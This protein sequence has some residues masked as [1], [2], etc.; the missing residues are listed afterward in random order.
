MKIAV[1]YEE[2]NI[3]THFG[4]CEN[5]KMYVV[6]ENEIKSSELVKPT[7]GGHG[8][9][10]GFLKDNGVDAL[11]CGGIGQGAR[12]A[13]SESQIK[14]YPGASGNA[15]KSVQALI[16]GNLEYNPKTVCA[17]HNHDDG[18]TCGEDKKGCH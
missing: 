16:D 12:D 18:H 13:L 4:H 8:A 7:K 9:L 11:I 10:A 6:E 15:D 5:F 2:G 17:H 1:T 3:Y 14:F